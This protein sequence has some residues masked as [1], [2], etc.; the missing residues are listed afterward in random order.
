MSVLPLKEQ[1]ALFS[2]FFLFIEA[3]GVKSTMDPTLIFQMTVNAFVFRRSKRDGRWRKPIVTGRRSLTV[4]TFKTGDE[5][6][7]QGGGVANAADL[8]HA[9]GNWDECGREEKT[10]PSAV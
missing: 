2:P 7:L 5:R 10:A 4:V 8:L 3:I 6:L 9:S 1:F